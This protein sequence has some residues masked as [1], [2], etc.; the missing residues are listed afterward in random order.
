M[1]EKACSSMCSSFI[2]AHL[3]I[4]RLITQCY[5]Y[6]FFYQFTYFLINCSF[7]V[8]SGVTSHKSF[9]WPCEVISNLGL[10]SCSTHFTEEDNFT[11]HWKHYSAKTVYNVF[12][13]PVG[14]CSNYFGLG[15]EI[16]G[17]VKPASKAGHM[18]FFYQ[19][20]RCKGIALWEIF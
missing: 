9:R 19:V 5:L 10:K 3:I 12:C 11:G 2:M 7:N 16:S 14:S 8:T 20:R 1:S 6:F 15:L 18:D 17:F 13:G 4:L